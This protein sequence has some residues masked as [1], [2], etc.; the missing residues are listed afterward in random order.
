MACGRRACWKP[1][2]VLSTA[3]ADETRLLPAWRRYSGTFYQRAHRALTEAVA[4]GHVVIISAG[5]GLVRADEPIGTYNKKL[6]LAD[7]PT[8]LLERLLV[9]EARRVEAQAV[10]G[11]AAATTDY[12]KLL[13]R[14]PWRGARVDARLVTIKGVRG[15]GKVLQQLGVAFTAFWN[16]TPGHRP[17]DTMIERLT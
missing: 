17:G 13:R 5:Y 2:T 3:D 4:N 1:E 10:V 16:Q 9:D 12:A 6:H 7:W 14:T 11:F 15:T 8:G